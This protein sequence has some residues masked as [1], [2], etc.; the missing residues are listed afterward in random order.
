MRWALTRVREAAASTHGQ[1]RIAA[2]YAC[3]AAICDEDVENNRALGEHGLKLIA[4]LVRGTAPVNV[5]THCN[6]GSLATV[7]IGT[8]LAPIYQAHRSGIAVHVWVSETRPR[9]QGALTAYELASEGVP[10]TVIADD[11]AGLLLQRAK[12]DLC[13]VG[14]DRVA[15]N[16][17]VCN[18]IGTY[19]K[20]LAAHD[21]QIPF[22][23]ALPFSTFDSTVASGAEIVIEERAADEVIWIH[24]RTVSG[25]IMR[26]KLTESQAANPA[27][28]ITPARLI[29]GYITEK[30]VVTGIDTM[31]TGVSAFGSL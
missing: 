18:K 16:G 3:A 21:N 20:A 2:A 23:V 10:H 7:D 28:D 1:A 12:V 25:D 4:G 14:A 19:L 22:Y 30:G 31:A 11:A 29:G 8:A 5:L 15:R 13:I 17:D 9:N 24:G 6:T 27:F 26:V